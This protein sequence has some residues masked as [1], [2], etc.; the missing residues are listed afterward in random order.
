MECSLK[1]HAT[2]VCVYVIMCMSLG[3][4]ITSFQV[5]KTV[6]GSQ[7]SNNPAL[8]GLLDRI[9]IPK[10]R[11]LESPVWPCSSSVFSPHCL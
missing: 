3:Q 1:V 4:E 6:C 5:V 11:V 10:E 9:Q 2:F 8:K 7:K